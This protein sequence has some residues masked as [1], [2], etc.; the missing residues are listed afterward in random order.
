MAFSENLL[1][2]MELLQEN[3]HEHLL[4]SNIYMQFERGHSLL[5]VSSHVV[6]TRIY[7]YFS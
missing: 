3:A 7:S 1:N 2:M 5:E 6:S 4:I